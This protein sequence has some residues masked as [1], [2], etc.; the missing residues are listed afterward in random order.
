M[1]GISLL[2]GVPISSTDIVYDPRNCVGEDNIKNL[3]KSELNEEVQHFSINEIRQKSF[4]IS[5]DTKRIL[6]FDAISDDDIDI[7]VKSIVNLQKKILWVGSIG[8]AEAILRVLY[9]VKPVLCVVGSVSDITREQVNYAI[10]KG[11]SLIHIDIASLIKG[12]DV[13]IYIDEAV[14]KI[15]SGKDVILY[16]SVKQS[17]VFKAINEAQKISMR[18]EELFEFINIT[19]SKITAKI[20]EKTTV[21]GIFLT[22][23]DMAESFVK[24]NSI[25]NPKIVGEILPSIL[26]ILIDRGNNMILKVALKSGHVGKDDTLYYCINKLKEKW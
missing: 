20:L 14:K 25:K 1:N 6:S 24:N 8:L 4:N 3:F 18:N 2:D 15:N 22:G 13:N 12:L 19:L 9:P 16:T 7:V 17:D 10:S 21:S 26:T 5:T 11:T 23:G